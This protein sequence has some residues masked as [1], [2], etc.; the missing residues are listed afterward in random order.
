MK[1]TA[2]D[3]FGN[4][5]FG[6]VDYQP[7]GQTQIIVA[8]IRAGR[9]FVIVTAKDADTK[10]V[11]NV[12]ESGTLLDSY[13]RD[14]YFDFIGSDKPTPKAKVELLITEAGKR[15]RMKIM[16]TA[17]GEPY[18]LQKGDV[19]DIV[20]TIG[21]KGPGYKITNPFTEIVK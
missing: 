14:K 20:G 6:Q 21:T 4:E 9:N 11:V 12:Y 13:A 10:G 7:I 17:T 18:V 8:P 19:I 1:L 5:G 3:K 16:D 2:L 15:K